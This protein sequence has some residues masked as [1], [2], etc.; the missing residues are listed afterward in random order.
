MISTPNGKDQLYYETCR[1]AALK[2]TDEWNK[3]ELIEMKWFQDP[4]YNKFLEWTKRNNDTGEVE[5]IK[6]TTLNKNG[7][8]KWDNEHW[9]KM[10]SDGWKPR[11]PWYV[12][13]CQQFNNDEQKIAQELDVSFL[14]SASNVVSPEYIDMQRDL[15][16][17]EPISKK[18]DGDMFHLD[19][20]W[21]WKMPIPGHR[22]IL[23][24]DRSRGDSADKSALEM[25]DLDGVDDDGLP[26]VEQVLE[27]NG[28]ITGDNLGEIAY[29]YGMWYNTAFIVVEAIGG[30]GDATI[31]TLLRLGYK[32][33]YYDDPTL[34]TFTMQREASSLKATNDGKLPGFH[35]NSARFQML[36]FFANDISTNAIKIRSKRLIS[37]LDTWI[38]KNGRQDHQDGCHDDTIT[39]MAMGMFIY[40]YHFNSLQ[41]AKERDASFLRAWINSANIINQRLPNEK[42]TEITSEPKKNYL[43]FYNRSNL[44]KENNSTNGYM[45]LIK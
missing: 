9:K 22:Y 19:D 38:F 13:M 20:T 5:I 43:P 32:N 16:M 21:V 44:N 30:Y 39:C 12:T 18:E 24:C 23:S 45:W 11:S 15:N 25:I 26:C 41:A 7:E 14:G 36:A 17:R 2:G 28:K 34:K 42:R 8:I 37:E 33:M 29:W 35:T 10:E 3:F 31:T 1:R 40:K 4:R 27:Y 6:E